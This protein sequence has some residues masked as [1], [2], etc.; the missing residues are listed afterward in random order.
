MPI[1]RM[2]C[3]R[4]GLDATCVR[5]GLGDVTSVNP[6][7]FAQMCELAAAARLRGDP[8]SPREVGCPYLSASNLSPA[9]LFDEDAAAASAH[10]IPVPRRLGQ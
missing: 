6:E 9:E 5:S 4:C 8:T 3:A 2:R 7:M 10:S 1:I